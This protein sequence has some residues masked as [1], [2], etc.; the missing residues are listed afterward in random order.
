MP[1]NSDNPGQVI[2]FSKAREAKIEEKRR[3]YERILFKHILGVYCVAEGQGLKA[4]ELVDVSADGLSFQLPVHSKNLEILATGKDMAFRFYFSQD[5]FVPVHV[6]IT[7]ERNCVEEG[8]KYVR[9]GCVVDSASQ[10]YETYKLFVMFLSKYAETA[11]QDKGDL[12]FF[13]F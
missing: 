3:R 9:F 7:N 1:T 8:Q 13:F 6:K 12:K 5:T 4:V 2:N 11:Q 10:S